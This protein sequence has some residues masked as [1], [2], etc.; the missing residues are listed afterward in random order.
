MGGQDGIGQCHDSGRI[1]G[2]YGS[3]FDRGNIGQRREAV[4]GHGP[5][6]RIGGVHVEKRGGGVG[7][8]DGAEEAGEGPVISRT[9]APGFNEIRD[10][11]PR[12]P[13]IEPDS[14]TVGSRAFAQNIGGFEVNRL[15]GRAAMNLAQPVGIPGLVGGEI[16]VIGA[17]H[18]GVFIGEVVSVGINAREAGH[19]AF[20][21]PGLVALTELV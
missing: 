20:Q 21:T 8:Q 1:G 10:A 17:G 7:V 18:Q 13:S 4:E 11:S 9:G 3:R 5:G 19:L 12:F 2:Q 15:P 6:R 14:G 16:P